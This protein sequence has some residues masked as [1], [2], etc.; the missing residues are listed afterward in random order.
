MRRVESW[1]CDEVAA[2]AGESFILESGKR[3]TSVSDVNKYACA[4][5][6]IGS[7][8]LESDL[9]SYI[10]KSFQVGPKDFAPFV[11]YI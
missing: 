7:S 4:W 9:E 8:S 10:P 2:C 1:C 6:L 3:D 5:Q 11:V